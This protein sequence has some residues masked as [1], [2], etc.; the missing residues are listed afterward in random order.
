MEEG[1]SP[2]HRGGLVAPGEL[3]YEDHEPQ[4]ELQKA[5]FIV[6]DP[7]AS[8]K[9]TTTKKPSPKKKKVNAQLTKF[10]PLRNHHLLADTHRQLL[11]QFPL[12]LVSPLVRN[13][14]NTSLTMSQTQLHQLMCFVPSVLLHHAHIRL[15]STSLGVNWN[16]IIKP[17]KYTTRS[18]IWSPTKRDGISSE[19]FTLVM[20]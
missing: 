8:K 16:G 5:L 13:E 11:Q 18:V 2:Y 10:H 3:L 15:T 12:L 9:T 6:R 14:L 1:F 4:A 17:M 7:N 19:D 20:S